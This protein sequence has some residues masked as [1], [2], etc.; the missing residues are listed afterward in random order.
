[1]GNA[2]TKRLATVELKDEDVDPSWLFKCLQQDLQ[3]ARYTTV[4]SPGDVVVDGCTVRYSHH[5]HM[6]I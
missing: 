4:H 3:S 5:A 2:C 1:M 6:C